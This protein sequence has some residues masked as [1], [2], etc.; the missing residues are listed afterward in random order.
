MSKAMF[1]SVSVA[2][3]LQGI[4]VCGAGVSSMAKGATVVGVPA[5]P[6]RRL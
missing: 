4:A 6:M 2:K 1:D 5:R 3:V